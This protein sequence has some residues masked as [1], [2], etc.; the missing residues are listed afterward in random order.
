MFKTNKNVCSS[1]NKMKFTAYGH[2]NIRATH[3]TT[4]EFTKDKNLTPNGDCIVGVNADFSLL[5][6]KKILKF[7]N[8]Q[9]IVKVGEH[10]IMADAKVNPNFCSEE[11]IVIRNSDFISD[12]TLGIN[13][14]KVAFDF[15]GVIDKLKD[16]AQ[17]IIVE[18]HEKKEIVR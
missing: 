12:R 17:K 18:I 11:E 1:P 6:L 13:S 14:D 5:E 4:F 16:P 2:P 3:K 8:I 10:I 7:K 9:I 15:L